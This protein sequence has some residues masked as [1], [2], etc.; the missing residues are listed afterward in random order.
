MARSH[1]I[2]RTLLALLLLGIVAIVCVSLGNWQ[3]DRAAQ[4]I[5]IKQE[6]ETGRNSPPLRITANTPPQDLTPWRP[7]SARGVWRHEFTVL[8]ENRN[9]QGRPGYWVAT[10]MV[11]DSATGTAVLVL[12]GWL[13]RPASI[14]QP[15]PA[16]PAPSTEQTITGELLARV[17]RLFELSSA[18]QLPA[19]LPD[20]AQALP[21]IQNLGLDVYA[22]ATGL[23]FIPTV[24]AQTADAI[25]AEGRP[26][27]GTQLLYEWPEPSLDSDKNKGYALQWFGFAA[28]AA[29]AWLVIVWRALRRPRKPETF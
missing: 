13:P 15:L 14:E 19:T 12:R 18:T 10:P 26:Q 29:V 25:Q 16:I 2:Y 5:A 23:K 9:Y 7:A 20:P 17:P 27:P 4:R 28:I 8:L 1:T 11:L 6:I 22:A 21:R 3:L 24:L